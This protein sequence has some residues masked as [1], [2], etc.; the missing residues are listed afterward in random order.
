MVGLVRWME[1]V[2][3]YYHSSPSPPQ[4]KVVYTEPSPP[5]SLL[6]YKSDLELVAP[7]A[8]VR[9]VPAEDG[10]DCPLQAQLIRL[11]AFNLPEVSEG[12]RE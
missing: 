5:P 10:M 11:V 4:K 3:C 9:L 2:H 1:D 12:V 7:G 6:E 8:L